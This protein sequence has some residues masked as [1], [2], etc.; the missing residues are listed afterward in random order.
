MFI[1]IRMYFKNVNN[2]EKCMKY[3]LA[4]V[5]SFLLLATSAYAEIAFRGTYPSPMHPHLGGPV[6]IGNEVIF[7]ALGPKQTDQKVW[8][9]HRDKSGTWKN[10]LIDV[11]NPSCCEPH[12]QP[13]VFHNPVDQHLYI[14]YGSITAGRPHSSACGNF[15]SHSPYVKRSV[16]PNDP[17]EWGSRTVIPLCGG[18]SETVGG[19]TSDG[20]IH[21][22]GQHQWGSGSYIAFGLDY[23]RRTPAGVWQTSQLVNDKSSVSNEGPCNF[24]LKIYD[25]VLYLTWG[26][27]QGGCAGRGTNVYS[28]IS[29]DNG[30]TWK[31]WNGNKSFT[32]KDGIVGSDGI[33]YDSNFLV[34]AG[35][36][37]YD[38]E[39]SPLGIMFKAGSNLVFSKWTGSGWVRHTIDR[40]SNPN[41]AS[42]VYLGGNEMVAFGA[43]DWDDFM[44]RYH[45]KDG[46]VTWSKTSLG[47][48]GRGVD[49]SPLSTLH[50]GTVYT[51]WGLGK[52]PTGD[53]AFRQERF[54]E[55]TPVGP[56]PLLVAP[57]EFEIFKI[58]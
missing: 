7:G 5:V 39:G 14:V 48:F 2:L 56:A 34:Y 16:R 1:S 49:R 28:A 50:N 33:N 13:G 53:I 24:D 26:N 6:I 31:S 37:Q 20:T 19:A 15:R 22:I 25:D 55:P 45:S 43:K 23:V 36:V 12:E 32:F 57:V 30:D 58:E 29:K 44:N 10:Y 46:G 38:F 8:I 3:I 42:L 18:L 47:D 4:F 35:S 11:V 41:G 52:D 51:I 27:S 21:F 9:V 17:S 54:A 40:A